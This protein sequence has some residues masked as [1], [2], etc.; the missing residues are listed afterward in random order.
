MRTY[1]IDGGE[2]TELRDGFEPN[3]KFRLPE[4]A[5]PTAQNAPLRNVNDFVPGHLRTCIPFWESEILAGLPES[6][7]DL[8][9]G[10]LNGVQ[11]TDFVDKAA[12]GTFLGKEYKGED[13]TAA[14]FENHVPK[15]FESWVSEQ[16]AKLLAS[17]VIQKWS[18]VADISVDPK[19]HMV[20]P[21]GVEPSKPRLFLDAR[22]LNLMMRHIPF[23][24]DGVGKVAQVA[25]EGAFQATLDHASGFHHVPVDRASWKYLGLL[26]EGEYYVF[27]V[28][29]F[30]WCTSP[31]IYH[32]LSSAVG[33]YLRAKGMPCLVWL[34]DFYITNYRRTKDEP[35]AE[36]ELAARAALHFALWVFYH[37]GYF[38]SVKKCILD[39]T[40]R[41]VFLGITCDSLQCRFEVPPDKLDK[42][43]A[44]ISA[45]I[46][47]S[48]ITFAMLEKLA[49]KCTSMTV[50]VPAARLYTH[51]MYA[52]NGKFQR[53]G[54]SRVSATCRIAKHSGLMT[55]LV[56]WLE[57][58][59][60]LNGAAWYRALH[61]VLEVTGATDA[62]SVGFGGVIRGPNHVLF[63][64]AGDFTDDWVLAHINEKEG[65][66][67]Q[68]TL[69]L[70]SEKFPAQIQGSTVVVDVDN[71][72]LF[73]ANKKGKS[74]NRR[75]HEVICA[76]FW[77]QME[78]D[79]SLILRWVRSEDNKEADDLSRPAA[80]EY[81]RLEPHAF[82][83]LWRR[84]GDFDMDLMAT[85]ASAQRI[86][87]GNVGEGSA[88]AFYSRFNTAGSAGMDVLSQ[89][90]ST[91]PGSQQACFGFCFPPT[92]MVGVVLQ[93]LEE[94]EAHAVVLVPDRK[95]SW[96]PL[97][98]GATVQAQ[99]VT[100]SGESGQFF[101]YH[102][103]KGKVPYVFRKFGMR[104][105]EV[106][107]RRN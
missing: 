26:W 39:P 69:R 104:A 96:Y 51:Y 1:T 78:V 76:L 15:E 50:A 43:E 54:R 60:R 47:S 79:F 64:A 29:C 28:L 5:P 3:G 73:F 88:L 46:A 27:T 36:Q 4:H 95:D 101:R 56:K 33:A 8:M 44:I 41:L 10:W 82:G 77:L 30:G 40:T 91:M 22:W 49:G 94:R 25:W 103:K 11:I 87:T 90:V 34:D 55:E 97:L 53:T 83:D 106:D 6:D 57:V 66:A 9:L 13:L 21:L 38:I 61:H 52:Q 80:E 17:S 100:A 84:F 98:Q 75:I 18:S 63:E 67:L 42:L 35:P 86:P 7:R 85:T 62:S 20:M 59:K 70:Y 102:H 89:D 31:Y 48:T 74:G 23:T 16:I 58:R 71:Q 65:F 24:M 93:H 105:V 99:T 92:S 14:E 45:A 2:Q 72:A 37:A 107:F 19:P 68:E 32:T 12:K 81:V